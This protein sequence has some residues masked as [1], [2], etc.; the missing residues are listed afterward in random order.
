MTKYI[1]K[2]SARSLL[3]VFLVIVVVFMLLRFMPLNGYFPDEM[4]KETDEATR[5]AYL[6]NQG[7]LDHP[8]K[9]FIRFV[10]NLYRT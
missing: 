1:L 4:L 5:M 3:T 6:R 7:L 10:G 8:V 2:R 9:Q